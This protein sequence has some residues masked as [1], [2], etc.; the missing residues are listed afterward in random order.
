MKRF[1][2]YL[3]RHSLL[4]FG[5][6]LTAGLVLALAVG[7]VASTT[8]HSSPSTRSR[9]AQGRVARTVLPATAV[10]SIFA[11]A[12]R[13]SDALPT[14]TAGILAQFS[15][16]P[17]ADALNPGTAEQAS[18]RRA[19]ANAGVAGASLFLVPTNKGSLCMAWTPDVY[20]GGCTQGFET[21]TQVVF[22]RGFR[23]GEMHLWGIRRDDVD[24]IA[25]VVGGQA[26]PVVLGE[27]SFFYEGTTL[28]SQ[29]DLTLTDGSHQLV[30]V[31]AP[32]TLK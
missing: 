23:N 5:V 31:A 26:R 9:A 12:A 1:F 30:N 25:A 20:G 24:S 32:A 4:S 10:M 7:A 29:L 8:N 21:G 15:Q 13:P 18:A 17:V 14:S 3:G 22:V 6:S 19:L 27:N 28:P 16:A 2:N 11:R